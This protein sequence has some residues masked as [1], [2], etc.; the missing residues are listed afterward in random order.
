MTKN[1]FVIGAGASKELNLPTGLEL[2][3]KII[4]LLSY[5]LSSQAHF[6]TS[7]D[8]VILH[9]LTIIAR[10]EATT[11]DEHDLI[12][13]TKVIKD[14]LPYAISIDNLIDAHRNDP[15]IALIGKVAIT[16]AI[17]QAENNSHLKHFKETIRFSNPTQANNSWLHPFFQSLTEN[18]TFEQVANKLGNLSIICFNYDRSLLSR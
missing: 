18:C 7:G 4:E 13:K 15:D 9:A 16:R 3:Q 6:S 10:S 11:T 1:V 5:D 12:L 17:L 8:G 2:K 14:A